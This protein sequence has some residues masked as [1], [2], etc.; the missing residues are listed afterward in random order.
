MARLNL[1]CPC[2]LV[3][4][5]VSTTQ[6]EKGRVSFVSVPAF[7]FALDVTVDLPGKGK[8]TLDIGYGGAYYAFL[9]A[10]LFGLDVRSSPTAELVAAASAVTEAVQAQVTLHHPDD[11]DLAFLYGTILTD[12]G[13]GAA[14][15]TANICVFAADEVDRSP[16]GSGVTAR[17]ALMAARGQVADHEWRRFES[18][19]GAI[20]E[21]RIAAR[22]R[23]G[24]FPAIRAEVAGRAYYTGRPPSR[25]SRRIRWP[26][27]FCCDEHR[28]RFRHRRRRLGH[29]AFAHRLPGRPR[30]T[31]YA[32]REV[33]IR[34]LADT[35]ENADYLPGITLPDALQLTPDLAVALDAD[36]VLYASR[37]SISGRSAP[38]QPFWRE[39]AALVLCAKGIEQTSGLLLHEIAAETLP[40]ARVDDP[41]RPELC[42]R[43][44]ARAADSGGDRRRG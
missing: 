16:T 42:Q 43:R 44:C 25:S 28:P 37:R 1:Q 7:A 24:D 9:P 21:G 17:L 39:N 10:S 33:L 2:G 41:V 34:Q 26:A 38:R 6:P 36:A 20:F 13:D 14:R 32:R 31:L 29:G 3:E 23:A 15:P 18:V 22:L 40:G 27:G 12:G 35:R 30:G 11:A 19:T 4:V 5:K 8:I